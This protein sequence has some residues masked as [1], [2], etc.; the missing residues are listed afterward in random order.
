M[1]K[2]S[3]CEQANELY[4]QFSGNRISHSVEW[5]PDV[6]VDVADDNEVVGIQIRYV[7]ELLREGRNASVHIADP[8][9]A[10]GLE[11]KLLIMAGTAAGPG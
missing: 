10:Y 2:L 1:F 11:G 4:I 8:G 6:V 9:A 7:K 5:T 3:W